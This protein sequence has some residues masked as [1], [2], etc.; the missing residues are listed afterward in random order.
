MPE[1]IS[2]LVVGGVA[3]LDAAFRAGSAVA[4][5]ADRFD[6]SRALI[7]LWRKQVR[8]GLMPGIMISEAGAA[9]FAVIADAPAPVH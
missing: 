7:Y 3:I 8:A 6:V 9:A 4:A 5:A 1:V 2:T